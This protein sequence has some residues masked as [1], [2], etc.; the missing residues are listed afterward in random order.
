LLAEIWPRSELSVPPESVVCSG[1]PGVVVVVV[2]G[3][4]VVVVLLY[5][6]APRVYSS[7][8]APIPA[9]LARAIATAVKR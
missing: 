5:T 8:H 2:V 3:T 6:P 7:P 4:V 9:A 1:A